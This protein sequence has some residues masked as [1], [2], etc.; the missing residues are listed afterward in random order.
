MRRCH[1]D[2]AVKTRITARRLERPLN[3]KAPLEK[4]DHHVHKTPRRPRLRAS[5]QIG[6]T[7]GNKRTG[8]PSKR[9]GPLKSHQIGVRGLALR[10]GIW[11]G[12]VT[13]LVLTC[14]QNVEFQKLELKWSARDSNKSVFLLPSP[15]FLDLI[16]APTILLGFIP[17]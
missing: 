11:T 1:H 10:R 16:L 12:A 7:V 5:G 17:C 8:V 15:K 13:S 6:S 4:C 14:I 3:P 2:G 9:M